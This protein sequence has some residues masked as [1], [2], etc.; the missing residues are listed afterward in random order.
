VP[1]TCVTGYSLLPTPCVA[2]SWGGSLTNRNA[3]TKRWGGLNSLKGMAEADCW[4]EIL[5]TPTAN[6]AKNATLPPSL[7]GRDSLVGYVMRLDPTPTASDR[8]CEG[9]VRIYRQ[10]II[11]GLMTDEEAEAILGKSAWQGQGK[12]RPMEPT[13]RADSRDN[14]GGSNARR[15]ARRNGTY[16]GR[17]LNP[18]FHEWLM[19]FPINWTAL[20]EPETPSSCKSPSGSADES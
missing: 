16:I 19:G 17:E 18:Q 14:C 3:N 7:R 11:A 5:P 9:S 13:P 8:P 4:P 1:L 15:S 20:E 6:D 12:I 2:D 10:Q